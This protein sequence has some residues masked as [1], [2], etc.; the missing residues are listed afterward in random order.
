MEHIVSNI[1]A[2]YNPLE[3]EEANVFV[4]QVGDK[5]GTRG[6]VRVLLVREVK[7]KAW[8]KAFS[9]FSPTLCVTILACI[10]ASVV[11]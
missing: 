11:F 3:L 9:Y 5:L 7:T 8:T 4:Q 6:N 10:W 2:G 1:G